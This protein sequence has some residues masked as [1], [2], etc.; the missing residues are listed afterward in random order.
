[1]R[2]RCGMPACTTPATLPRRVTIVLKV[3]LPAV[4]EIMGWSEASMAKRYM[5]VPNELVAAIADQVGDLVWSS[6]ADTEADTQDDGA[7]LSDH[8][9]ETIR[10][11]ASALPEPWRHRFADL[12]DNDGDE[13]LTG[14]L[15]LT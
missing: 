3:S 8:E 9:R 1:M 6:T 14:V 15:A 7:E 12:L 10:Q 13:G 11:L 2:P 5:H 4:M